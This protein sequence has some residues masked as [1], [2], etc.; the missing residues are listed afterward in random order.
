MSRFKDFLKPG[1]NPTKEKY[2]TLNISGSTHEFYKRTANFYGVG[3]STLVNNVL[4][5]WIKVYEKDIRKDIKD[6]I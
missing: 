5:E 6:N 4:D 1:D 3:I 2:K